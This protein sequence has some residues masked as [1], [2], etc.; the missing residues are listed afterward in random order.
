MKHAYLV[1][2]HSN[3]KQLQKLLLLLDDPRNDIYIHVD[4]KSNLDIKSVVP[5]QMKFSPITFCDRVDVRWGSVS[6]VEAEL[7]LFEIASKTPHQYYHLI[8]GA[9]L[10]LHS[11]DYIHQYFKGKNLEYLGFSG[12]WDIRKRIF[13]RNFFIDKMKYPHRFIRVILQQ[14][15]NI[16][17]KFQII[18]GIFRCMPLL[19]Y[20]AGCEWCSVTH[21]FVLAILARRNEILSIYKFSFCPDEI[22]KQTFAYNTEFK[23]R[24]FNMNDEFKGCLR[25]IDWKRGRPYIWRKEDFEF[26]CNSKMLFSRKFDE[27][28][29]NEI[30]DMI[31][32]KINHKPS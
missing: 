15:R 31:I 22:Y 26:L 21:D 16:L 8:S 9:D 5:S 7:N 1:M 12:N 3:L 24:I 30:I 2:V 19:D 11:Q 17:N 13:C 14:I 27:N 4:R 10:P 25:E 18:L 29:D 23:N 6:L 32:D 20:Q 28:V